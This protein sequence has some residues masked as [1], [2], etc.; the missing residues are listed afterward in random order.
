[1]TVHMPLGGVAAFVM[2]VLV[3]YFVFQRSRRAHPGPPGPGDLGGAIAAGAATF[4]VL[5]LL[6]GTGITA[7]APREAGPAQPAPSVSNTTD[8]AAK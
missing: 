3:A 5:Y 2:S 1:M 7:G 6:L 4:G 8:P